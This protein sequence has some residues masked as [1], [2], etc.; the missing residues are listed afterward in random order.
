MS[1]ASELGQS[2]DQQHVFISHATADDDFVRELRVKL[3]CCRTIE[4]D[5]KMP[6]WPLP[7]KL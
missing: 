3:L 5:N 1:D 2:S 4:I 7:V 6:Q